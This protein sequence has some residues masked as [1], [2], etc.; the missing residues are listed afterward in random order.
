MT[1]IAWSPLL[2]LPVLVPLAL[3][4]LAAA[5]LALFARQRGAVLRLLAVAAFALALF[6]PSFVREDRERLKDVVAV[7]TDR[8]ASQGLAERPGQTD[9]VRTEV[10]RKLATMPD[11]ETR[12][13]DVQ[14][15]GN[16]DGTRLFT[17]LQNALADVPPERMGGAILITDGVVHDIPANAGLLGFKA[18]VHGLVT[19]HPGERDRRIELLDTPRFG[20]VG[21]D[22]TIRL[23]VEDPGRQDS[24]RVVVR[25]DGE[26]VSERRAIP[27]ETLRV[28]IRIE[29][30]G[31]NVVEIEVESTPDELTS[32]NNKAVVTIEGIREKLRV[33]LVSGQPHAGER[34]WRNILKSDANVDLV[35]F[36]ILRPPEKQDGTPINELSLIAFPTRELFET[37]IGE[38]D[39][40]I[41]DRYS[42]QTILPSIYFSNIV[43]YVREGGAVLIAAGPEFAGRGG[44]ASSP[45]GAVMPAQPDGQVLDR[46]YLAHITE[47]GQKHPVTRALPGSQ[48]EP[49]SWGEWLRQISADVKSGSALM[50]GIDNKPLLV[51]SRE[52][53]GRMALLLSDH[54]WLWARD[55]RGGGPHLDLLRRLGHWLM[56]EP[57][58]EEEALRASTRGGDLVVTRQTMADSA[59]PV[60]ITTPSGKTE[61]VTLEAAAPGLWQATVTPKEAGLHRLTDGE[62][63]AF[64]SVGPANPREYQEVISSTERLAALAGET[65]GSVRRVADSDGATPQVPSIISV[66][67]GSRFSG[68]DFIGIHA[69]DASV[70]RGVGVLPVFLGFLGLALLAASLLSTWLYE[71]RFN[72]SRRGAA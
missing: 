21:K 66:S 4:A 16:G 24:M 30:G 53:K 46:P 5:L 18:P 7:V 19:G 50:S 35:H 63:T 70:V 55:Y 65:G 13:V 31:P 11:V 26:T 49:P 6:N 62:L 45:L 68:A 43:R 28:P 22:Q 34:T 47:I 67:A 38:F 58:L 57:D 36:T 51:L 60:T 54:A 33:L 3:V 1:S 27:G 15:S 10:E 14:E 8:S 20:I 61:T 71:G 72:R 29:H 17:A 25:R 41:F 9:A 32:V 48:T 40:I 39:L 12:M 69:T 64:V 44:L 2:P 37:K 56:K 23:R 52:G 42:N 59:K